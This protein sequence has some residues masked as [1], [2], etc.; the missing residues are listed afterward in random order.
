MM[1]PAPTPADAASRTPPPA[2]RPAAT[3]AGPLED[4]DIRP[5]LRRDPW[6]RKLARRALTFSLLHLFTAL[7]WGVAP[8]VV[9]TLIVVDLLRRRPL[10]LVRF[11]LCIGAIVFGQVWGAWLLFA[12]W[13]ASGGGLAWRA[14]NRWTVWAEGYWADWNARVMA[15]IYD[16]TYDVEDSAVLRDGPSLLLMRHA[17]INDT[18]LPIGLITR[19]HGVRLRIVLKAELLWA[20]IVDAIGHRIP[21][22]FIRRSSGAVDRELEV[23]RSITPALHRHEAIMIFPEGTR[24]TPERRAQLLGKLMAKDPAAAAEAATLTHVLPFRTGGVMA[25]MDGAPDAALVFC[26]H[27][28]YERTARLE[29]FIAGG[30]YRTIVKVKFWRVPASAVPTEPAARAAFLHAEWRKVDAWV[31]KHATPPRS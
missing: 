5:Y 7:W 2:P 16:I 9:P 28:G 25:L 30:L 26:A 22:A 13:L 27:T 14:N 4:V 24:F 20:P 12:I 8:L 6:P 31:A 21:V 10:L 3:A 19:V 29:D 17:S 11:Y 18:I 15:A 23:V 1:E